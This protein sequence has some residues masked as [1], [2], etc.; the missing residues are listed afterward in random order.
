MLSK[1]A[2]CRIRIFRYCPATKLAEAGVYNSRISLVFIISSK[3]DPTIAVVGLELIH[4]E[5]RGSE[6]TAQLLTTAG[7]TRALVILTDDTPNSAKGLAGGSLE[8]FVLTT[9]A[10]YF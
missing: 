9:L 1:S 2:H 10:I 3:E 8:N 5:R 7:D 6:E 4:C